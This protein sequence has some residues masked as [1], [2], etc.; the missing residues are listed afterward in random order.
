MCPACIATTAILVAGTGSTGGFLALCITKFRKF[1][2][3][4]RLGQFQKATEI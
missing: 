3:A 2:R 4:N 1:F